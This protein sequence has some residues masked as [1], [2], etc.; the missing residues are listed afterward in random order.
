MS[1]ALSG[2]HPTTRRLPATG[3]SPAARRA[4]ATQ[5][6]IWFNERIDDCGAAHHV[7]FAVRFDGP[8]DVTALESALARVVRRH[9]ALTSVVE[10]RAGTPYLVPGR[11]VP[12]LRL[13]PVAEG[14]PDGAAARAFVRA[15]FDL[16]RGPLLRARLETTG[17]DRY[18]L[19]V[20]VHHIVFDGRSM[21]VFVEE[22]ATCYDAAARRTGA[23]LPE[24]C[25]VDAAQAEEDRIRAALP[26]ARAYWERQPLGG[27][28]VLPWLDRGVR[29]TQEGAALRLAVA[30]D[31]RDRWRAAA[32]D[33]GVTFF[34]LLVAGLH[35]LL[36][37]YGNETPGT[38]LDLSTRRPGQDDIGAYV[39][40]PPFLSRP[41]PGLPFDDFAREVRSGLRELYQVRDVPL[42]RAG[43]AVGAGVALAAVSLSYRRAGAAPEFLGT[44]ARVDW[45]LSNDTSRNS[46][47]IELVDAPDGMSVLVLF[48]SRSWPAEGPRTLLAH[49]Q[50]LLGQ[51]ADA[52]GT[53][54]AELAV[55][56]V[57]PAGTGTG[58]PGDADDPAPRHLP[59]VVDLVREQA[60]RT[61]EAVAVVCGDRTLTYAELLGAA[62]RLA[63]RLGRRGV[64]RGSLVAVCADRSERL[65][66]GLLAV[67][68][69]GA[70]Y[71]PMD[72]GHPR[73]RL[74]LVRGDAAPVCELRDD[75][76]LY[77]GAGHPVPTGRRPPEAADTAYV[78][79][80]SGSTGT[81]KGVAVEHRALSAL[82]AAMR[83]VLDSGPAHTW[84]ALT[85]VSFDIAH[86]EIFL[87]LVTG[88]TLVVAGDGLR[89][90]A[91]L[92]ALAARHHVTHVQ[93]TPTGWAALVDGGFHAP[94][95]VALTGGEALPPAL[96]GRLLPR[97]GRLLNVYGPT[98]TTI[99]SSWTD[100]TDPTGRVT[101]GRALPGE[102]LYVLDRGLRPAPAGIP[103]DLYVAGTGLARGYLRRPGLTAQRF[104]PDPYGPPGSRMYRTGDRAV[105]RPDGRLEFLGR[106]DDQ[107]KLRGYRIEPGEIEARL[108]QLPGVSRAAVAVRGDRL[109]G[110]L[111]GAPDEGAVRRGL[112]AVLPAYMVPDTFVTLDALPV[113]PNGKLDRQAL[114]APAEPAAPTA[115]EPPFAIVRTIWREVLGVPV[116]GD[117]ESLFDLGGHSITMTR[118]A[119]RIWDDLGVDVPLQAFFDT[120]TVAGIA[121]VVAGLREQD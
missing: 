48:P 72:P 90:P 44:R 97:V 8:L 3:P 67:L 17:P 118:I 75:D 33:I 100:I 103:G 25:T 1:G 63:A 111:T 91:A 20:V 96:A 13:R 57:V 55:S 113:T 121:A 46:L 115:G 98:E 10:D 39:N 95:A 108:L 11:A 28:T 70:A 54:L 61:P 105:H 92:A 102:R 4:T 62:G 18:R 93:A 71:I 73:A 30:G 116:L 85:S 22:L 76:L 29:G 104:V 40:E 56:A 38:A 66:V 87:P 101:I 36:F 99:W 35:A 9:P 77:D 16:A 106:D 86:L 2:A 47:R 6:G 37:R 12:D 23:R 64:G 109:V 112:A 58:L 60:E 88:G 49:L 107:F 15:P 74:D 52:P 7:P 82:L 120:P 51:V 27:E 83:A 32:A 45:S 53:P 68:Q 94:D 119:S 42:G 14:E 78:I 80:T 31:V 79:Y 59:T 24:P 5:R 43:L 34:E 21:E 50:A 89:D 110:Y 26:A 117:D 84:L 114:P 19:L 65:V 41:R 69:A 81:P